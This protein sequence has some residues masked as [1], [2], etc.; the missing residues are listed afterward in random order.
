MT[1]SSDGHEECLSQQKINSKKCLD[2]A[3]SGLA[4]FFYKVHTSSYPV[5][6]EHGLQNWASL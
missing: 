4:S 2:D 6:I 1:I 3:S 5:K